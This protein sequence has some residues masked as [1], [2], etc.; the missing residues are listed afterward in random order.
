MGADEAEGGRGWLTGKVRSR[1]EG[2]DPI[3]YL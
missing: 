2:V 3:F 1:I